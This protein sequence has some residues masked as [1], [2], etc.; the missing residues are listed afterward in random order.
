MSR[1]SRNFVKTPDHQALIVETTIEQLAAALWDM[2][3]PENRRDLT[4]ENLRWLSRNLAINNC[5][6]KS[7]HKAKV[8]IAELLK[9]LQ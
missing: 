1:T 9:E 5:D 7:F 2:N 8:L 6:H 4:L 3:I